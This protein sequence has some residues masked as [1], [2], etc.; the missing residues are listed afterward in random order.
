[1][2]LTALGK[3][4]KQGGGITYPSM[5]SSYFSLHLL[6]KTT[7]SAGTQIYVFWKTK[8]P[9]PAITSCCS[10]KVIKLNGEAAM[11]GDLKLFSL[12]NIYFGE[13]VNME[14]RY[15]V[16]KVR[17]ESRE[18]CSFHPFGS[19]TGKQC[20]INRQIQNKPRN[21][22]FSPNTSSLATTAPGICYSSEPSFPP[23]PPP[24]HDFKFKNIQFHTQACRRI[25]TRSG[26][27]TGSLRELTTAIHCSPT[28]NKKNH[29]QEWV[30]QRFKIHNQKY[31]SK[32]TCQV[33]TAYL[34]EPNPFS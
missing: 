34:S 23:P 19:L 25:H 10:K 8:N 11:K 29:C 3:R 9:D 13:E 26:H 5:N 1:M 16:G 30:S 21:N 22:T 7:V 20:P 2:L 24:L 6:L 32:I 17:A 12:V 14:T 28:H 31:L 33:S 18:I 4:R 15:K 27:K